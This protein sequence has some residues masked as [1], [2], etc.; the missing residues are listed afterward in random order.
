MPLVPLPSMKPAYHQTAGWRHG[1]HLMPPLPTAASQPE[2][3]PVS[4]DLV[5]P[6]HDLGDL[7]VEAIGG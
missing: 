3:V 4:R 2:R 5:V 6:L 7:A 1:A